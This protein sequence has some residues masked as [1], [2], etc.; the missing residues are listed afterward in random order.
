MDRQ[1]RRRFVRVALPHPVQ[2]RLQEESAGSWRSALMTDFSAAG[3]RFI[4]DRTLKAGTPVEFE[5]FFP[6]RT[7]PYHFVTSV[8]WGRAAASGTFEHGVAFTTVTPEQQYE[9]DELVQFL[10]RDRTKTSS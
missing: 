4:C 10:I 2:Y 3:L 6:T 1:E 8:V 7:E 9:I 5:M